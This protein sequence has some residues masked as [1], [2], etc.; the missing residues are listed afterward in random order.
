MAKTRTRRPNLPEESLAR[1][2]AELYGEAVAGAPVIAT[3]GSESVAAAPRKR[4][5]RTTAMSIEDLKQDYTHVITDLRNMA[6]LAVALVVAMVAI[7][8]VLL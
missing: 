1:A 8:I 6:L 4:T 5:L 2:R 3:S 7:S